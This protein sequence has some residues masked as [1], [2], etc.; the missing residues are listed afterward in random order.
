MPNTNFIPSVIDPDAWEFNVILGG[1][2]YELRV[3][4][5]ENSMEYLTLNNVKIDCNK[6]T[7]SIGD[8]FL[9]NPLLDE[10]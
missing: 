2:G 5:S 7:G 10:W 9:M 8:L 1:E 4:V 3:I 6:S